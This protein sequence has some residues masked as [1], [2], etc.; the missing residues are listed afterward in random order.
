M[1]HPTLSSGQNFLGLEAEYSTLDRA[2]IA[3]A[4][5]PYEHTVSYGGGTAN[6]PESILESS[7]YVEFWD[8]EYLRE[9][10]FDRGIAT[11]QHIELEGLFDEEALNRIETTVT[12]LLDQGKFVVTLGGEH[13]IS[14]ATVHAHLA[15]YPAMGVLQFD[16]HSDLRD[17][18]EGNRFSHAS[19]M[20]RI[21]DFLD[22][23]RLTQLGIRAQCR[24]EYDLI[25][26]L[27]INTFFA[28]AVRNGK[29]GSDWMQK[30]IDTLPEHV[31]VTFD[32]D[33]FDSSIM[34]AT[35]TPEP[36][37][38]FWDE[39]MKLIRN[40]GREKTIVG[41]DVVE[42]SP[43][44]LLPAPSFLTA[45]LVYKFLNAAYQGR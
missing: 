11:L 39:T 16:A 24:E 3:I 4:P 12:D 19:V 8:E 25:Q 21:L 23:K 13:S 7:R 14:A 31:Y 27:G 28:S 36:G 2:D 32:V 38:F 30:L 40:I 42:L 18:Y 17:S 15:R 45:K 6:G 22:G 10:C 1:K 34:P 35:G 29:H 33:Y 44:P 37:G 43:M 5:A 41:F 20:A 9:L 26:K